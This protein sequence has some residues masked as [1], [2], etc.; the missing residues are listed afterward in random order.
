MGLTAP[1]KLDEESFAFRKV[2]TGQDKQRARWKRCVASDEGA[3]GELVAQPYLA[4]RFDEESKAAAE[5]M[6]GATSASRFA[7]D[8][9]RIDWMDAKTKARASQ[10]LD[11]ISFQIGYPNKW[12]AYDF[13]VDAKT[14][15]ANDLAATR[16]ELARHLAKIG[17]PLDKDDWAM[18]PPDVTPTPT[19]RRRSWSSPRESSSRR[20]SASRRRPR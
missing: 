20:S 14:F 3:L 7:D 9:A 18:T 17:K 8:L 10:K 5:E 4:K 11:A 1:S 12:R 2:L 16:W 15:A 19:A 13:D 6:I